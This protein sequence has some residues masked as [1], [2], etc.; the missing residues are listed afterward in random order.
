[1]VPGAIWAAVRLGGWDQWYPATQ[2]IAFTPY[3]AL[4]SLVPLLIVLL[5]RERAASVVA[6]LTVL[7]LALL[8]TPRGLPDP[9]PL[10]G[11]GGRELRV[12]TANVRVGRAD[13]VQLVELVR[14]GN[15]DVLAIQELTE[16]FLA[17]LDRAGLAHL[18]PHR[19]VYP[20]GAGGG[21]AIYSREPLRDDGV[22][23]HP[24]GF[25][26]AKATLL[27][28]HVLFESV[29]PVAPV[30]RSRQ[31]GWRTSLAGQQ[32]ATL[33]GPLRVLAGDFNAT[34]DHSL[35]RDLISSGYRDAAAVTGKGFT[36]TWGPYNGK[37]IPPVALDRILADRRI[38]VRDVRVFD[39]TGSD[40][41]AV[42]AVLVLP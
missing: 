38:G 15:V 34:L 23:K 12:L 17:K 4:A 24:L 9:D 7:T 16:P 30:D 36:G 5:L 13:A 21:S 41:R 35:L 32:P 28:S 11:A 2:L 3:V 14:S 40:H 6:G 20:Y 10:A 27:E 42:L 39:Q 31:T 33:D 29:H 22:T 25:S 19:V 18:L 37:L 8:V 26:Q 1:M